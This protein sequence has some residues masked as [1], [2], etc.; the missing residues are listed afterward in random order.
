LAAAI[1]A[2]ISKPKAAAAFGVF[3]PDSVSV[4]LFAGEYYTCRTQRHG[5][6]VS[7]AGAQFVPGR[8]WSLLDMIELDW[9]RLFD[10]TRVIGNFGQSQITA[11]QLR[12]LDQRG[13]NFRVF[14]RDSELAKLIGLLDGLIE[15]GSELGISVTIAKAKRIKNSLVSP[16]PAP[17]QRDAEGRNVLHEDQAMDLANGLT[18]LPLSLKDELDGRVFLMLSSEG[19]PYYQ[20]KDPPFG[21]A[22]FDAFPSANEDI[23][24]ASKCLALDRGTACVM[25]LMR[26]AEVGL[27]A[28]AAAVNVTKQNDWGSYLRE[29]EKALVASA[30]A[31]GARSKDEQFYSEAATSIDHLKRAWRNATMHVDRSYSVERAREIFQAIGSF[32]RHLAMKISEPKSP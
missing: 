8:L 12:P 3:F 30:K 9:N 4:P 11:L 27:T 25:H 5:A 29:I 21:A 20:Q 17:F 18:E 2:T 16:S 31:S 22:V 15:L 19:I 23:S 24:E 14:F 10:I 6:T 32:M 7:S 1:A 28:L 13:P 26:A